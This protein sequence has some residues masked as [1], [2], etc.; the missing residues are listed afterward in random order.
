MGGYDPRMFIAAA[1]ILFL[2]STIQSIIGFVFNL[3]AI[4]LL[5]WSGLYRQIASPHA[6]D[7]R[8]R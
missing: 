5:I 7:D 4:P 2:S 8:Y 1:S 6:A 3:L